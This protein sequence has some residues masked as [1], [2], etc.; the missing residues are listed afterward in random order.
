MELG[1]LKAPSNIAEWKRIA[2]EFEHKWNFPNVIGA[3][4]GKHVVM[5]APAGSGSAFFNYRKTYSTVLMA[6]CDETISLY[7]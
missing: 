5:F 7:T 6:V 4:D 2:L 1:Y 3:L